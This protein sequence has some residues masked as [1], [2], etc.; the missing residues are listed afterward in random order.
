MSALHPVPPE[1]IELPFNDYKSIVIRHYSE[2]AIELPSIGLI[3]LSLYS[4][5][6][7]P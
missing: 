3:Q 1:R 5:R 7:R 6:V 4:S 2:L